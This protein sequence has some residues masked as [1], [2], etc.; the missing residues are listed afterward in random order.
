MVLVWAVTVDG[1]VLTDR[2]RDFGGF[3]DAVHSFRRDPAIVRV[4]WAV[5]RPSE[6]GSLASGKQ[7]AAA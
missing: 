3:V 6:R 4:R 5:R 2:A 1:E 7:R